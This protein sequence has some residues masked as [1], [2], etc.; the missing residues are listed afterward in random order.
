MKLDIQLCLLALLFHACAAVKME[1]FKV[2]LCLSMLDVGRNA[3]RGITR[4][5]KS[6][7]RSC[8]E[9]IGG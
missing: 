6:L 1:D 8:I 5:I 4:V 3:M 2:S 9:N 7:L